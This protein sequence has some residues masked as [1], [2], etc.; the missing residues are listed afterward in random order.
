MELNGRSKFDFPVESILSLWIKL[1][2]I[3]LDFIK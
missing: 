3:I 2:S 1:S